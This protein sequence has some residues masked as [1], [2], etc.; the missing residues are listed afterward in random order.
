MLF[1]PIKQDQRLLRV[2]IYDLHVVSKG[3]QEGQRELVLHC[4]RTVGK[5]V[6]LA[7]DPSAR[8]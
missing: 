6:V 7:E 3:E 4:L 8:V 2:G 1:Y 5:C